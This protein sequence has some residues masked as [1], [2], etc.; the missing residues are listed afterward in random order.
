MHY[1]YILESVA[2]PYHHY[3]GRTDD[4][5]ERLRRHNAGHVSHT[6][7]FGP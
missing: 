6:A 4:P 2:D 1:A 7:K 3:T 5:E